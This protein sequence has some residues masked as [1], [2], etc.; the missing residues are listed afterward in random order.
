MFIIR[1]EDNGNA[2][3][4]QY[5]ES[6]DDRIVA[7][8]IKEAKGQEFD[9]AV[10]LYPFKLKRKQLSI[11]DLYDWYTS[12]TRARRYM[13]LLIS[14]DELSWLESQLK[15]KASIRYV[16]DIEKGMSP[17]HFAE[18][19]RNEAK[20]FITLEQVR[21]R[22]CYRICQNIA[23]WLNG[24]S[25]PKD[26][27]AFCNK[28]QLS[29]WELAD[30]V[31]ETAQE[32]VSSE[33]NPVKLGSKQF[34]SPKGYSLYDELVLYA[35][36]FPFL[37][38]NRVDF[39]S[40]EDAIVISLESMLQG[41]NELRET[42]LETVQNPLLQVLLLRACGHS[43]DAAEASIESEH[44]KHCIYGISRDLEGRSLPFESQRIKAKFLGEETKDE[45]HF[46]GLLDTDGQLVEALC[47]EFLASLEV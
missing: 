11:D 1:Q 18:E 23:A 14:Q 6:I 36:A 26:L 5:V 22:I 20:T 16:F 40:W 37:M 39:T 12:F 42:A 44:K 10:I 29:Y 15:E 33:D 25:P 27:E 45:V 43:W 3:I 34:R 32:L 35:G 8:T 2:L 47:Y 30:L 41:E 28:G 4:H 17:S 24:A 19:M 7:Y 38:T 9:A 46:P 21:K 13:A 31:F